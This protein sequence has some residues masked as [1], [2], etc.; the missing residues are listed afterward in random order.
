MISAQMLAE[1]LVAQ[2]A[3]W[4]VHLVLCPGSRSAPLAI[5]LER[6]ARARRAD[7]HVRIDERSAGFLALGLA[8][9]N[10][11]L[12]AVVTTSGT[13]VGNLLPAVMEASHSGVPLLVISA[14][15]P[16]WMVHTGA[17]QTTEQAGIFAGFIRAGARISNEEG[18]PADWVFQLDRLMRSATGMMTRDPG[19]AHLNVSFTEPLVAPGSP[20]W[21]APL[22]S[23]R[24]RRL[25]GTWGVRP[26]QLLPD[27]RTVILVGDAPPAVGRRAHRMAEE[28]GIPLLAE[29]SSNARSGPAIRSY[30]LL[31]GS[32]LGE[33]IER[34]VV[35]GHPTLSRPVSR[36][37]RDRR[38][39]KVLVSDT[40]RPQISGPWMRIVTELTAVERF[41]WAWFSRWVDA[42]RRA[43][44]ALGPLFGQGL[45][46]PTVAGAVV[47]SLGPE[48][49]LVAGS[50]SPIRDLDLAPVPEHPFVVYANRG[51]AGIDGTISTAA[52]IA[53]AARK[54]V[55]ALLG[56][57]TFL[58]DVGGLL[59]GPLERRPRLRLVVVND[60]GGSIF[61][62]LEQ[63]DPAYADSF[64]RVF[65]TPTGTRL[66]PIVEGYGWDYQRA[67]SLPA[68][69]ELLHGEVTGTEVIEVPIGRQD[70]RALDQRLRELGR[71]AGVQRG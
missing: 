23:P 46:G 54:P 18:D 42:D 56:D 1:S 7:L 31:L 29:P 50:S 9:A 58:H 53:L 16:S 6:A 32:E 40:A 28:A 64:E 44:A 63:G 15:R 69:T 30:R 60:E 25:T 39:E 71:E 57:L 22:P 24:G 41:P 34:V 35:F 12:A 2:L 55:T 3:E 19:P 70:R 21:D 36:L 17:N 48:D 59:I 45:S 26:E 47:E 33:Q 68:L 8:K 51:L 61:H 20:V 62:S 37:L 10:G 11:Q 65:G 49:V 43:G 14:D 66:Q 4:S 38:S 27:R 13:A 5:A 67:E 52:G